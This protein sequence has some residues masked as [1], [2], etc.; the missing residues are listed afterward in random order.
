MSAV[1][2]YSIHALNG[3]Q[4]KMVITNKPELNQY[5][6]EPARAGWKYWD[7]VWKG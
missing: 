1:L 4:T 2:W 3:I 5:V 7:E 6:R